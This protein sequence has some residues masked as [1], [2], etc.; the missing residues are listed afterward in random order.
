MHLR[1]DVIYNFILPTTDLQ[2]LS[3]ASPAH[4]STS[5][6]Q[7]ITNMISSIHRMQLSRLVKCAMCSAMAGCA[8]AEN[9]HA[10]APDLI[11]LQHLHLA[12][13]CK[14]FQRRRCQTT[15]D[16]TPWCRLSGA[17]AWAP[18]VCSMPALCSSISSRSSLQLHSRKQTRSPVCSSSNCRSC[19]PV[20]ARQ[21]GFCQQ[22]QR[23]PA[24]RCRA[25]L[26]EPE[27]AK[28]PEISP[29]EAAE[30]EEAFKKMFQQGM[31]A[32]EPDIGPDDGVRP[33]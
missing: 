10:C 26:G 29:E 7:N 2:S 9:L 5:T 33:T 24:Q 12:M 32:E 11:E 27:A 4:I 19:S 17:A 28:E 23:Q 25:G 30:L 6:A 14:E 15:S 31:G 1:I 18:A 13:V 20:A 22:R 8:H 21:A 16:C 3:F